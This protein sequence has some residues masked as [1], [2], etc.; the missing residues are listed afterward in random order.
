M[1]CAYVAKVNDWVKK[2]MDYEVESAIP[3]GRPKRSWR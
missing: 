3:R 1:V 2:C